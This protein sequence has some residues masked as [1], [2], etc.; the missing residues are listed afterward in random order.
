MNKRP[1]VTFTCHMRATKFDFAR[2][3][4]TTLGCCAWSQPTCQLMSP[5]DA[6][7]KASTVCM[8]CELLVVGSS[9]GACPFLVCQLN[10]FGS[11]YHEFS[12]LSA[13]PWRLRLGKKGWAG[14]R[15]GWPA[16]FAAFPP[17]V[18]LTKA[19]CRGRLTL[20]NVSPDGNLSSNCT[21]GVVC[22]FFL[23][24]LSFGY[25]TIGKKQSSRVLERISTWQSCNMK[26]KLCERICTWM[27]VR[28]TLL[29]M[30]NTWDLGLSAMIFL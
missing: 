29:S 26:K 14:Q 6:F 13:F 12:V 25:Q 18:W 21:H 24:V 4:L 2:W 28:A 10:P 1:P 7:Q 27:S 19:L 16:Q 22:T 17:N 8:W 5:E 30:H 3:L 23:L 11:C 20:A 15:Q 9:L